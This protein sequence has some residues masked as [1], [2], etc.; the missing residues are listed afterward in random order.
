MRYYLGGKYGR[1]NKLIIIRAYKRHLRF[2]NTLTPEQ[3]ELM[4]S[5]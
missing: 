1:Y 2:L 4:M 3:R 5:L